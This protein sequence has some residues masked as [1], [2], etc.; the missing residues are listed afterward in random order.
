[1]PLP[2]PAEMQVKL[3]KLVVDMDRFDGIVNSDDTTDIAL[4]VG[5]IPS[6]RKL[7]LSV[8]AAVEWVNDGWVTATAYTENNLLVHNGQPYRAKSDHT[9]GATTEPDV[10]VD[11]ETVWERFWDPTQFSTS[12]TISVG[13]GDA[14]KYVVSYWTFRIAVRS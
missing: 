3:E 1:M 14:A 7:W 6:L 8:G 11:W 5:T 10:G 9:S 12:V 13:A 2:S 4:D